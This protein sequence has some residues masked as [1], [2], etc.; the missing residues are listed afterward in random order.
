ML[1]LYSG[2]YGTDSPFIHTAATINSHDNYLY[3]NNNNNNNTKRKN[4]GDSSNNS[5]DWDHFK[6]I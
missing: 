3:N 4:K 5:R 1:C 2:P 6:V